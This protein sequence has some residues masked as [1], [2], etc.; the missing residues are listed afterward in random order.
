MKSPSQSAPFTLQPVT[1]VYLAR[2][3]LEKVLTQIQ[4]SH[5]PDLVS[6]E[7]ERRLAEALTRYPV[8]RRGV[9]L[10][11][12]IGPTPG[13]IKPEQ[14]TTRLF[15][16]VAGKWQ[17]TV[18]ETSVSLETSS[19]DSRND[20]CQRAKEVFDAVAVVSVPPLVDR[21]GLRY[22]D[23]LRD[24]ADLAQLGQYVAPSLLGVQGH[25][26]AE[27]EVEYSITEALVRIAVDER[28]KVRCGLL[29]PGGV[30]DPALA[31]CPEA[32]WVLDTDIF[33]TEGGFAFDSSALDERLR[34]YAD[35]VY[36][37]FRWATTDAFLEAF[38]EPAATGPTQ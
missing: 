21:V 3:P 22:V 32:S 26:A 8:R 25:A 28:L 29:P 35:H 5:T 16:D 13:E 38:S 15:A 4:F 36:S 37:F 30:F 24:S 10:N 31:P 20:F 14:A 27:L 7:G 23:R 11:L 9:S 17:V 2:A 6:D 34:R 1:E 18:T 33:T 19:Y 12:T